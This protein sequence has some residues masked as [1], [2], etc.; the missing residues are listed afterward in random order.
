MRSFKCILAHIYLKITRKSSKALDIE[1]FKKHIIKKQGNILFPQGEYKNCN[2]EILKFE[3]IKVYKITPNK[4]NGKIIIYYHGG[5]YVSGPYENQWEMVIHLSNITKCVVYIVYYT[6]GTTSPFPKALNDS[7]KI[8]EELLKKNETKNIIFLGD[9]AGGGLVLSTL[10]I[11][12]QKNISFPKK[13]ILISPWL[14][15]SMDNPKILNYIKN[16]PMLNLNDLK[17]AANIYR[18]EYNIKD[19]LIS[20]INM[21]LE[22]FPPCLLLIGTYDMLYPDCEIFANRAKDEGYEL[23]FIK[24]E[25]MFHVW[26]GGVKYIPEAKIA[27]KK[28]SDFITL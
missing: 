9:S 25:K 10:H 4:N 21:N 24:A 8:Y 27:L 11:I 17:M 1:S 19:I 7:F 22:G 13:I 26:T 2:Y 6:L 14:D 15:L 16:D 18:G 20:P 28:I 12:R 3:N 5:S 23:T